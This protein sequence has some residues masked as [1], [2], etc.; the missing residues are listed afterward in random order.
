[1]NGW[2]DRQADEN[3]NEQMYGQS[4]LLQNNPPF[5]IERYRLSIII[6]PMY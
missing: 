6:S 2:T 1:M 3:R 5:F 4:M